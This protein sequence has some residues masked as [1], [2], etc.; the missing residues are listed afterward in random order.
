MQ[1]T[2]L[3]LA[4]QAELWILPF[5]LNVQLL[6]YRE[7]CSCS[8]LQQIWNML[9]YCSS[10][11]RV[12]ECLHPKYSLHVCVL[13]PASML[14]PNSESLPAGLL[15]FLWK[16]EEASKW[17]WMVRVGG[18]PP[19]G[20]R[21]FSLR[22]QTFMHVV[23]FLRLLPH[24]WSLQR[25]ITWLRLGSCGWRGGKPLLSVG[26]LVRRGKGKSGSW[27]K[28]EDGDRS[29]G[30]KSKQLTCNLPEFNY[31]YKTL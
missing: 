31:S 15:P 12:K 2:E 27:Y 21:G 7:P 19:Q 20:W 16:R 5:Q 26:K 23:C 8:L 6:I 22:V 14:D 24:H 3:D 11:V 4:Q 29:V 30:I 17:L 9:V 18:L 28:N 25:S 13:L 10:T 1:N